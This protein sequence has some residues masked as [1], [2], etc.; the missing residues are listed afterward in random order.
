MGIS[1]L[2]ATRTK[3]CCALFSGIALG[4]SPVMAADPAAPEPAAPAAESSPADPWAFDVSFSA[5]LTS[6]YMFRGITQTDHDPALQAT[7]EATYGIFYG[8][9][10]VSN[11]DFRAPEP[12]VEF[13]LYGGIRPQLGPVSTDFGYVHYFYPQTPDIEYG[14]A[15]GISSFSPIAMLELGSAAYYAPDYGQTGDDSFYVEGNA[16]VSLP[17]DI[18][19]SGALGVQWYGSGVGLSDYTTWN[20]GASY[21]WKALT[22]DLRYH[23]TDLST[24]TCGNEYPSDDTCEARIVATLKVDTSWSA[25]RALQNPA[26]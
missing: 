14:E 25:L 19:L 7:L 9:V 21:T 22:F 17:H 11:V 8:G 3:L 16:T 13:D 6:D 5:A 24:G 26:P 15:Y 10:F 4:A 23:D 2:G 20:V 18:S 12:D 1:M